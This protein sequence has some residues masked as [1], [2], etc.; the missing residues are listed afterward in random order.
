MNFNVS[1]LLELRSMK[2]R[3]EKNH[4]KFLPFLRAAKRE[5][6]R[7]GSV[8]EI[9]VTS[10]EGE[11]ISSNIKVQA[12]DLELLEKAAKLSEEFR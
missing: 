1:Q 5:A 4:P 9:S 7:E 12:S 10:P 11:T 3:F 6:L 2:S 8:I